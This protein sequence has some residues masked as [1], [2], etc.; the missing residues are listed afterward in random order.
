MLLT[1]TPITSGADESQVIVRDLNSGA[2]KVLLRGGDAHYVSSGHLVYVAG[3]ELQ[4]IPF[5]LH[6]LE[7]RGT[8]VPVVS[9]I[10]TVL[11][12]R[13]GEF[14]VAANG[15][16]AY[17]SA[18][19][20]VNP[21]A[22]TLVWVDR[23]G[24]E[25]AIAAQS[26]PYLAPRLSP[27]GRRIAV[28]SQ[29]QENDIWVWDTE[30]A[31]ITRVTNDPASDFGSAWT[32]DGSR[33][34]FSSN[35][36]GGTFNLWWQRSDGSGTA[37]R[38]TTSSNVHLPSSVSADGSDLFFVEV[39]ATTGPDVMRLSLDGTRRV[40]PVV[41][42]RFIEAN[43]ELSPDRHW[44]AYESDSSGQKEVYVQPFPSGAGR[45]PIS[46]AGG[47]QP[48]WARSGKELFYA[49]TDGSMMRVEVAASGDTWRAGIPVEL[50]RGRYELG[51]AGRMY[52]VSADGQHFLMLKRV[53]DQSNASPA[54]VVVQNFAEELKTRVPAK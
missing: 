36:E 48:V 12:G 33:V 52:D 26:R 45:W 3:G 7:V 53:A 47:L 44:L 5:D 46:T 4:A 31:A 28:T 25:Q 21:T 29:D 35:R 10:A 40:T 17:V 38:L 51:T 30:R 8:P 27:E 15:T 19:A 50:F 39:T 42:T 1:V 14:A 37:E 43:G 34:I 9:P 49:T 41:Q 24:H 23:A 11:N 13:L 32:P 54:I 20:G 2:E 16:L 6:R 18:A 22:R